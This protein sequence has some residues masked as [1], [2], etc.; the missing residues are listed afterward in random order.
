MTRRA[1]AIVKKAPRGEFFTYIAFHPTTKQR[2]TFF[3]RDYKEAQGRA[4]RWARS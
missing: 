2:G 1:C 3:A 4:E